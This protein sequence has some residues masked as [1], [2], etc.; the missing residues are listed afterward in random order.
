MEFSSE[1]KFSGGN[2][3]K[4]IKILEKAICKAKGYPYGCVVF[5]DILKNNGYYRII[6]SHDFAEAFWK[7]DITKSYLYHLQQMVLEK[8]PL[9]YLEKF[10]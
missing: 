3:M 7:Y 9:K 6:F 8:E 1:I 4:D 10:L 2:K 5:P